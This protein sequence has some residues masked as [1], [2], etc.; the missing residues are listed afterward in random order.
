MEPILILVKLSESAVEKILSSR[1]CCQEH[2]VQLR[3]LFATRVEEIKTELQAYSL[4]A[5]VEDD[6]KVRIR[7]DDLLAEAGRSLEEIYLDLA[8]I[9]DQEEFLIL[10][11]SEVCPVW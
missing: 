4:V 10:D 3:S 1:Q 6:S 2:L 11:C 5:E 7:V 8:Q 9:F